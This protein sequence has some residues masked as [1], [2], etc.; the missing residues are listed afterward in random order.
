MLAGSL[1]RFDA[2]HGSDDRDD[3]VEGLAEVGVLRGC[4]SDLMTRLHTC[5][6]LPV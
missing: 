1:I 6:G 2:S 5:R 3:V 4:V